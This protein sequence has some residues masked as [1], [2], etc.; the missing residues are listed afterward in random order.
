[1]KSRYLL[2]KFYRQE[3]SDRITGPPRHETSMADWNEEHR[4]RRE[5]PREL[6]AGL[7]KFQ[8]MVSISL[9]PF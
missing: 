6:F 7:E 4:G 5:S 1:M 8:E 3:A 2:L 9:A